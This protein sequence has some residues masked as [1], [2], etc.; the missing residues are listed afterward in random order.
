MT[1][2]DKSDP[3]H[4][5]SL[6]T[7]QEEEQHARTT[8]SGQA[9]EDSNTTSGSSSTDNGLVMSMAGG[10]PP[11]PPPPPL[12]TVDSISERRTQSLVPDPKA[13][14]FGRPDKLRLVM[15]TI[16]ERAAVRARVRSEHQPATAP[17]HKMPPMDLP[18]T[19][20]FAPRAGLSRANTSRPESPFNTNIFVPADDV[21]EKSRADDSANDSTRQKR[22]R[23][24]GGRVQALRFASR[25]SVHT[26]HASSE[27]DD[28]KESH[29]R[30]S[31]LY[32]PIDGV[33]DHGQSGQ[34]Q[35]QQSEEVAGLGI[36]GGYSEQLPQGMR[37]RFTQARTNLADIGR[38]F[39]PAA[40]EGSTSE[41]ES[42]T[43]TSGSQDTEQRMERLLDKHVANS[44]DNP[45]SN[46]IAANNADITS[47]PDFYPVNPSAQNPGVIHVNMN[48]HN[49]AKNIVDSILGTVGTS[50]D[51]YKGASG[52]A[53][54]TTPAELE[55]GLSKRKFPDGSVAL[56]GHNT[57]HS[58]ADMYEKPAMHTGPFTHQQQ[59]SPMFPG[60][61]MAGPLPV[62]LDSSPTGLRGVYANLNKLQSRMMEHQQKREE[63][64]RELQRKEAKRREEERRREEKR[65]LEELRREEK[66][67]REES[68]MHAGAEH[69]KWNP[70][71]RLERERA[72]LSTVGSRIRDIPDKLVA[73]R[74][75]IHARSKS[76][77]Q[78]PLV[79][80]D[81]KTPQHSPLQP[82][83]STS[84]PHTP[85]SEPKSSFVLHGFHSVPRPESVSTFL[86]TMN[87][88]PQTRAHTAALTMP[89]TQ[90][91]TPRTSAYFSE[92]PKLSP[93]GLS[94]IQSSNTSP[95][96]TPGWDEILATS[97]MLTNGSS[98][99]GIPGS[100]ISTASMDSTMVAF[101]AERQKILAQ[102]VDIFNRQNFLL[103]ASR[104]L[105]AFGAPL[106]RLEANLIAIALNLDVQA[107]FAVLPGIILITF[108]DEDTRSSETYVV[109]IVSG[110]D[111]YR[112]GR[113]NRTIRRV[114]KS[115]ISVGQG[116]K[117][118]ER[119]LA[120]PPIY[121]WW[122]MIINYVVISFFICPLF[123]NGSWQDAG[124]SAILGLLVALLQLLAG[125]F[126]NYAN[127]FEVSSAFLVS[128][129]AA[130]LQNH[131]C[132]ATVSFAG[133]VMLLPGLA[134]TTSI[135]EMASRN[136]IS[137]TVRLIFA[138]CRCFMLGYGI[139]VGSMLG[140]R[141]LGLD[142]SVSLL[143]G[144]VDASTQVGNC[145]E[146]P[147]KFWWFLLLPVLSLAFNVSISA[148]WRQW[149]F[150][151]FSGCL[152]YTVSYFSSLSEA[153]A[154][155]SPAIASF[156]M[157]LFANILASF[158]NHRSA[159]EPIL[160][161]VQLLVPGSLG[162]KTV[163]TFITSS[164]TSS[165]SFLY[166]IFS[167]SLSIAVGLFLSGMVVFPNR[168]K[169]VGLMTF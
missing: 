116:V 45:L 139:S 95:A 76:G 169:R 53:N 117:N 153:L 168:K 127:L 81:A 141:V 31:R 38:A 46:N 115:R 7:E 69:H 5:S 144:Q 112:L 87:S 72:A 162:L 104:A 55:A 74:K 83:A 156:A 25:D 121:S 68:E 152:A 133:I 52:G 130:L 167:T 108:G 9:G 146:A 94:V 21:S 128:F 90:P 30:S 155:L 129:I 80:E 119:I 27:P 122:M 13:E 62:G 166:N 164:G 40:G 150:M 160:G 109:R 100:R 154:P 14:I 32:A 151:L 110:Y 89:R 59:P 49:T 106:H 113:T 57:S 132:F 71:E 96:N 142:S 147:N 11:P 131:V 28:E 157:G 123:W 24:F 103:V 67:Q 10:T 78:T 138:L 111:M 134:L 6:H 61:D 56:G 33:V 35:Q 73:K 158:Y 37:R 126:N 18:E 4:M 2:E 101:E 84:A 1:H 145:R 137:G 79:L 16:G 23:R 63:R 124:M 93:D 135:I 51:R 75:G 19:G 140:S 149:P 77:T 97:G 143:Q 120:T 36:S 125:R 54:G 48:G 136:M 70:R 50:T 163:L 44:P 105:M 26:I 17:E 91:S 99:G 66:R 47:T 43:A 92:Q 42:E 88:S 3:D 107:S 12:H 161:G 20:Y 34:Q 82:T 29:R 41:S 102:L 98:I 65:K 22:R 118:L 64:M 165:G 60:I 85:P 8:S 39:N 159:V 15:P 148:H 58:T 114:L 86:N